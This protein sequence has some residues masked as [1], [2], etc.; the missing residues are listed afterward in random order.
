MATI[1][2]AIIITIPTHRRDHC[3][4]NSHSQQGPLLL[5]LPLTVGTTRFLQKKN[6]YN[7]DYLSYLLYTELL[8]TCQDISYLSLPSYFNYQLNSDNYESI[9]L[10]GLSANPAHE[11][12]LRS[13]PS[14]SS[15][16]LRLQALE[17]E[18]RLRF[19]PT[20]PSQVSNKCNKKAPRE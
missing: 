15:A 1:F 17:M 13:A 10:Y 14:R 11:P 20:R 16:I 9:Y 8:G 12:P 4:Y 5:Q 18:S 6:F 2:V 19:T 7:R 3:F